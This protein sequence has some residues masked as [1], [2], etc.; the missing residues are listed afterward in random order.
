MGVSV[1]LGDS[2]C[3]VANPA[4]RPHRSGY[5]SARGYQ[6]E[7]GLPFQASWW[8]L[9]AHAEALNQAQGGHEGESAASIGGLD[10]GNWET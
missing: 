10:Q 3:C 8:G 7:P 1:K 5:S 6:K 4:D 2:W 9:L